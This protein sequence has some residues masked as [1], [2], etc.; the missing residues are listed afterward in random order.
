MACNTSDQNGQPIRFPDGTWVDLTHD[1]DEN[2]VYWP[3]AESF[4]LDTV[5]AGITDSGFYYTAFQYC[6]AEHG[7]THLDAPIHFSAGKRSME[8]IPLEQ[9]IG[10][11]VVV[12]V[13]EKALADPDYQ[14]STADF[15]QWESE[16][17][18]LPEGAIV[19]L[20][21]GYG[22]YWPD[23]AKYMGTAE[24]GAAAVA[25]LHFPGLAPEAAQWLVQ[26]RSIHAIGLDTPSIDY[27][28]S[29]LFES[30]QILF[31]ENIPAFENLANLEQLPPTGFWVVA[32]PMKIKGGSGG[33]LRIAALVLQG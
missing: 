15:Q 28:Q 24:R 33:P 31:K 2:T 23:R 29:T 27:G 13:S 6:A 11:A 14:I 9:L 20:H 25:L 17:G 12:D 22:R 8:E 19:L 26:E 32:L 16:H 5:F 1:F 21:T 3:T 4:K 7:G 30:H 10:A 18:M